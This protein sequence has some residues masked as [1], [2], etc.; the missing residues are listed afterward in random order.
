MVHLLQRVAFRL[1]VRADDCS[2]RS[3]LGEFKGDGPTGGTFT[4]GQVDHA[5]A[6][7]AN[8]TPQGVVSDPV[9]RL[10]VLGGWIL[11]RQGG[12]IG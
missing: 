4:F 8:F 7:F 5:A 9:A 10:Y 3:G 1:E 11:E 12:E 6:A 2:G